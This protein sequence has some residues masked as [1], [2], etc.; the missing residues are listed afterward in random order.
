MP[1]LAVWEAQCVQFTYLSKVKIN[2]NADKYTD[3][4]IDRKSYNM[5]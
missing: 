4:Q 2:I 5:Q 3:Y 1:I